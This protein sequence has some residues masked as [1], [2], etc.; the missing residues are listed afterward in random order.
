MSGD[1]ELVIEERPFLYLPNRL[2]YYLDIRHTSNLERYHVWGL[3]D[4]LVD[5]GLAMQA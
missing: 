4:D 1:G 3:G 2:D 5:K